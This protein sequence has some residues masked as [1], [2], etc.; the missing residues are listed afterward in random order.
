[1]TENKVN[2]SKIEE[3]EKGLNQNED[4]EKLE[5]ENRRPSDSIYNN[6]A[7]IIS[8][9]ILEKI[10]SLTVTKINCNE[11]YKNIGN[12]CFDFIEKKIMKPCLKS[13]YIPYE[14][15]E[16]PNKDKI[17]FFDSIQPNKENTWVEIIEPNVPFVDRCSYDQMKFTPIEIPDDINE[18]ENIINENDEEKDKKVTFAEK[19]DI[20]NMKK[21]EE[22]KKKKEEEKKRKEK[23]KKEEKERKLKE[24]NDKQLKEEND[25][26]EQRKPNEND[27]KDGPWIDL[28]SY[29]LP[30]EL[31]ISEIPEINEL[32]RD[33]EIE[34]NRKIKQK[35]LEEEEKRREKHKEMQS[36]IGREFDSK[37]LTFDSNGNII[38]LKLRNNIESNLGNEF[39]WSRPF[40]K[41]GKTFRHMFLRPIRKSFQSKNH[42]LLNENKDK[43]DKDKMNEIDE[44]EN[45]NEEENNDK[46]NKK[47][48]S[49]SQVK[50]TAVTI[51]GEDVIRNT[52]SL[53][54]KYFLRF[55]KQKEN[56]YKDLS[57]PSGQNFDKIIPEIGVNVISEKKEKKEGG[58]D[59]TKKFNK[60]SMEE[61]SKLAFDTESLNSSKILSSKLVFSNNKL[62]S[63]NSIN[64]N[65]NK[66]NIS[67]INI[68][69]INTNNNQN[70]NEN[71]IGYS[72]QFNSLD[73]PLIQN[74][75]KIIN[76][77]LNDDSIQNS[78]LSS[79]SNSIQH[80]S[81]VGNSFR[82]KL[83]SNEMTLSK[84]NYN[85]NLRNYFYEKDDENNNNSYVHSNQNYK[86]IKPTGSIFFNNKLTKKSNFI[87]K[88]KVTNEVMI[89][90][91]NSNIIKNRNWGSDNENIKSDNNP[92]IRPHKSNH[93]RELG[94]RIVSTKLP[95]DRRFVESP[96]PFEKRRAEFVSLSHDKI[97]SK[98][99]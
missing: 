84:N 48:N 32:R 35:L 38:N 5:E 10:I 54:Q 16:D 98:I 76:N 28:P 21:K 56:Q 96:D 64:S 92:Y 39:Y 20:E 14:I 27:G 72:K 68:N 60:P 44:E 66:N 59:F 65:S 89:D 1:M 81:Y 51:L 7:E 95:R 80:Y 25:K 31:F 75:H 71:Y 78:Q 30:K 34:K 15:E 63:S 83:L 37:R 85:S 8:K 87:P 19:E 49:S 9:L 36:R 86:S 43:N 23:R 29:D 11:I 90:K 82:T 79:I 47:R 70:K 26:K 88:I 12:Y 24:E 45:E 77:N 42:N 57:Q 93:I 53:D 73:N 33:M 61:F 6:Q 2:E 46:K 62:N 13:L 58:L 91:F 52:N 94:Y 41:E 4:N 99:N 50:K 17:L 55:L 69:N 22:E 67:D 3:K 40:I 74:A 97:K 18:N